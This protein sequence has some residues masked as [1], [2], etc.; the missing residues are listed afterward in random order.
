MLMLSFWQLS[1]LIKGGFKTPY[2]Y[3]WAQKLPITESDWE[4]CKS[5]SE[6]WKIFHALRMYPK[7]LKELKA[8]V[9]LHKGGSMPHELH[10]HPEEELIVILGGKVQILNVDD[11]GKEHVSQQI[12]PDSIVYHDSNRAHTIRNIGSAPAIILCLKWIGKKIQGN[13]DFLKSSIF[14]P[15]Y[16]RGS[17]WKTRRIFESPTQFLTKLHCHTSLME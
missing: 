16:K 1:K 2:K 13:A 10:A 8:H 17:G 7:G 5:V 11:E 9:S 15:D 14:I 6:R 4:N 12:G 3:S